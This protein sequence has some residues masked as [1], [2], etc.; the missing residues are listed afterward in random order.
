MEYEDK[1]T[2]EIKERIVQRLLRNIN[3]DELKFNDS[4]V[5]HWSW[6]N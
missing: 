3:R 6:Y 2:R 4:F 5:Y 1:K